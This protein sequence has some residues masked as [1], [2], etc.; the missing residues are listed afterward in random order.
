MPKIEFL[1]FADCP[2][3]DRAL[4]LLRQA[5]TEEGLNPAAV[6]IIEIKTEAEAE[7]YQFYGSPTIR[8]NGLDIAPLPPD[9]SEPGL[10]CRGYQKADGRISPLP[11]LELMV[12]ALRK[13]NA[14][15]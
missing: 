8:V 4:A 3:H 14:V 11:P 2:S 13:A 15:Q 7:E 9:I 5:L 6:T 10:S 1:Y 12:Q